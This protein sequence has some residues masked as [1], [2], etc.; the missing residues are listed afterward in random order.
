M[1]L[2]PAETV[3][4][5][6]GL[7]HLGWL[8]GVRH[9]GRDVLPD[10]LADDALLGSMEEGQLFGLDWL[11]TLGTIPNEYLYYYYFTRDAVRSI[12]GS[13]Q[14]R[15]EYLLEQHPQI[16][17]SRPG[18]ARVLG[19]IAF[20]RST[21]GQRRRAVRIALHAISRWPV[22]P[23]A[24]LALVHASTGVD[25]AKLLGSVRRAGRGIT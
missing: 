5:Y 9:G 17:T 20:A 2:D 12:T 13:G 16:A 25:P 10:L 3:V 14:T 15:G 7:N 24:L 22:A 11:R 4:D 19:Q 21:M 6:V 23:H 1:G 8:R 18:H